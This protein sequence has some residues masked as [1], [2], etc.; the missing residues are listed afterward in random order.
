MKV[1]A[2]LVHRP[3]PRTQPLPAFLPAK[4]YAVVV[5]SEQPRTV[6][7]LTG[8]LRLASGGQSVSSLIWELW[9]TLLQKPAWSCVH[10]TRRIFL[11]LQC[12]VDKDCPDRCRPG[13]ICCLM[14]EANNRM[15]SLQQQQQQ[16]QRFI[17]I[18]QCLSVELWWW[19]R[20][21]GIEDAGHSLTRGAETGYLQQQQCPGRFL[22]IVGQNPSTSSK[23]NQ[24]HVVIFRVFF[25]PLLGWRIFHTFL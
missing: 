20:I 10:A 5:V 4:V 19:E 17:T 12:K 1:R 7:H 13:C 22:I 15:I 14:W 11:L 16:Q 23:S 8:V 9:R 6:A 2:I 18:I 25:S 3:P 24:L 21:E